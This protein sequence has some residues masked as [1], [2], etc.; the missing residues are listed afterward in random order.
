MG[1][2]MKALLITCYHRSERK[3]PSHPGSSGAHS[4]IICSGTGD[5]NFS[6]SVSRVSFRLCVLIRNWQSRMW[7]IGE[8]VLKVICEIMVCSSFIH[9]LASFKKQDRRRIE[10]E[11]TS[12]IHMIRTLSLR[13]NLFYT[14]DKL[15]YFPAIKHI[16][17]WINC[18]KRFSIQIV[19]NKHR[20]PNLFLSLLFSLICKSIIASFK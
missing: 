9:V 7:L 3:S 4:F 13:R 12:D 15:R 11:V 19:I 10:L 8:M 17:Y 2:C 5:L 20:H 1:I 18:S 14:C 6:A 16:P